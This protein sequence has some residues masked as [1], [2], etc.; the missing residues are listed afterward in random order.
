MPYE[1]RAKQNEQW[2]TVA[3]ETQLILGELA[4]RSG[5]IESLYAVEVYAGEPFDVELGLSNNIKHT[6]R[7]DVDTRPEAVVLRPCRPPRQVSCSLQLH[8][9]GARIKMHHDRRR[10]RHPHRTRPELGR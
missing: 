3:I 10:Y 4:R 1:K 6:R 9:S 7:F 2:V 8:T 5:Q